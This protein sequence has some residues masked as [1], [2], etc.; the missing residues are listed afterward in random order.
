MF[1]HN[2]NRHV[3]KLFEFGGKAY[4]R[5]QSQRLAFIININITVFGLFA[6]CH[7]TENSNALYAVLFGVLQFKLFQFLQIF[8]GSHHCYIDFNTY[9]NKTLLLNLQDL[10]D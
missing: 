4:H 2:I 3:E 10:F 1:A 8:I 5:F 7:R 9:K 6:T